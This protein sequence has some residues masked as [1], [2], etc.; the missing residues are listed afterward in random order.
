MKVTDNILQKI[1]AVNQYIMSR[2]K[3]YIF[4]NSLDTG[5]GAP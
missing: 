1:S 2:P 4:L 5:T 3:G